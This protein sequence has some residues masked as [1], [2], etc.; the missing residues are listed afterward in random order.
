MLGV[1]RVFL[2][3]IITALSLPRTN[4]PVRS[5]EGVLHEPMTRWSDNRTNPDHR[6]RNIAKLPST[7]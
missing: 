6:E 1:R 5:V 2:K 4:V 7:S 3:T